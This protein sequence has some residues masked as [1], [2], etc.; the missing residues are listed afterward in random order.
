MQKYLLRK[1]V[2]RDVK[3]CRMHIHR[4]WCWL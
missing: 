3:C 4:R 2:A 1:G